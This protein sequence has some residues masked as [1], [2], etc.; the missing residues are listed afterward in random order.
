MT[1]KLSGIVSPAFIEPHRALKTGTHNQLVLKGGRGSAKSSFASVE[2]IIQLIKNPQIHGVVMRKVSNT[3]RTTVYA[4]YVWAITALG[5]Y[6]K[7][8]CTVAPMEIIYKPTGQKIMFFGADDPGK[9]KSIKVP[10]GYIGYLHLEE[11]DQ[12][13][14]EDE[15]RNI[16]QSVL[17]GGDIAIEIKSFNPPQTRDN[18]ANMYCQIEKPGQLIHSSTYITTPKEWLGQRFIED[19]EFLKQIN[20][21]AY[22]HEYMGVPNATGGQ[23]FN[24]VTVRIIEQVELDALERVYQGLDWGWEDPFAW[25]RM[26]YNPNRKSL[27][28]YD[29][30]VVQHKSNRDTAAYLR[31]E[32]HVEWNDGVIYADSADPKSVSDYKDFGMR[33]RGV[34]KPPGSVNYSMKWLQSLAEIVIDKERCPHTAKE[35]LNYH[36]EKTKDGEI[37]TDYP[38]KDNHTIDATR[39]GM[40]PVWRVRGK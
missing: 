39:Y 28:I 40:S 20:P 26:K 25:V 31:D 5:L 4:Q 7:F 35:F 9:I 32:K 6:N 29:E 3:L 1:Y 19:A 14:G 17:R 30:Y 8:K 33:C 38:D 24:N 22:E 23:V 12:F 34:E 27:L 11:L 18:W 10:F 2:G 13:A 15:V 36:Y 16:E 37:I 21:T